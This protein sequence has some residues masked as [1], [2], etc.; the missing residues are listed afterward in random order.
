MNSTFS[1]CLLAS[2]VAPNDPAFVFCVL[3]VSAGRWSGCGDLRA[4]R[5]E[6]ECKGQPDNDQ[7]AD[8]RWDGVGWW[9][10]MVVDGGGL[11]EMQPAK[12]L[13][14]KFDQSCDFH[15]LQPRLRKLLKGYS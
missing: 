8:G 10:T 3:G 9:W 5:L 11:V 14:L 13:W 12:D 15:E 2:L 1:Q 6:F 4:V 7:Q